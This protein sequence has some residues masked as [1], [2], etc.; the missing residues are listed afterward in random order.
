[1]YA[2]TNITH[3]HHRLEREARKKKL[4]LFT[5]I[6]WETNPL[7]SKRFRS[8]LQVLGASSSSSPEDCHRE[9]A[10]ISIVS[11]PRWHA[12]IIAMCDFPHCS[13]AVEDAIWETSAVATRRWENRKKLETDEWRAKCAKISPELG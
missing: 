13:T 10:F 1:M 4:S 2:R 12:S 3:A 11:R 5:H 6:R 9:A 7:R 8:L